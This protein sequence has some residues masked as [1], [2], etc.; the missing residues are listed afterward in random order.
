M[1]DPFIAEIRIFPFSFA[2]RGWAFCNGEIMPILQNPALF[3]LLGAT[4]GGNGQTSF[5]LPDMQGNAPMQPG[6]GP[7]LSPHSL[8]ETGRVGDRRPASR[9]RFRRTLTPSRADPGPRG[10]ARSRRQQ[11]RPG[12]ERKHLSDEFDSRISLRWRHRRCRPPAAG[13]PHNNMMPYLTL[14][15][16]IALQG[17]YPP[18]A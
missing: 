2:P 1:A 15:F 17:V 10:G 5:A 6:E 12:V 13:Q 14:N 18:R 16:C 11:L 8:G 3:S 9:A 7:G 4:Y